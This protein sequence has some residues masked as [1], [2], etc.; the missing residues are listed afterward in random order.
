M[1]VAVACGGTGGHIFPGLATARELMRR[2]HHVTLWL[3]GKDVESEAVKGW[4]GDVVT[5]PAQGFPSGFSFAALT[6]LF[7]L[8]R[9]VRR[10]KRDMKSARPDVVLAMGSYASAGPVGAAIRLGIPYVL[11]ESNVI[12]GRAV[13][14]FSRHAACVAGCFDETR[15]YLRRRKFVIT[16]MPLRNELLGVTKVDL[17]AGAPLRL[18]VMGGSRG[19][20]TLNTLVTEAL[21]QLHLQEIPFT[22]THLTGEQDCE[23]VTATYR[24]AGVDARVFSFTRDM[25]AI[26]AA[27]DF[28]ISRAGAATCAELSAFGLPA[29]LIPYPHAIHD[30]QTFN[31]RAMEKA[32]AADMVPEKD[33]T[34][35]WLVSYIQQVVRR[36]DLRERM[37]AAARARSSGD[38][39]AALAD[40]VEQVARP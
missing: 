4:K 27:T 32:G 11:H 21:V 31:A 14:L 34:L 13:R 26:Y 17:P 19:A 24:N 10:V 38:G 29:L 18:L 7:K 2:G 15:F 23:S 39:A 22:V 35:E 6:T 12:P 36:D 3:A 16:G 25:G 28:V 9:A 20:R 37:A 1:R 8:L 40:L 30:H 33:L 5:V